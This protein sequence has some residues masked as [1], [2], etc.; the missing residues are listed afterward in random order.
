RNR[1]A[2]FS[3]T[4]DCCPMGA[5]ARLSRSRFPFFVSLSWQ[6]KQ[7]CSTKEWTASGGRVSAARVP[8]ANKP[9]DDDERTIAIQ[10]CHTRCGFVLVP[11]TSIHRPDNPRTR[12]M[13]GMMPTLYG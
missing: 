6:F 7:C 11:F 2:T 9:S 12:I 4:S 3:H 5:D 8:C 10:R 13:M 1:L